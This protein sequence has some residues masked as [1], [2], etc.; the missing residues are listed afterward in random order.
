[1]RI[2]D[3]E[4]KPGVMNA[5]FSMAKTPEDVQALAQTDIGAIV[6]GSI[7]PEVQEENPEPRWFPGEGYA[8]NSFGMPN[9]GAEYYDEH[10]D[11]MT[12]IAHESDKAFILSVAGFSVAD[13]GQLAE[14]AGRHEVDMVEL[15]LGCPNI[16]VD[17]KQKPIASYDLDYLRSIVEAAYD[18]TKLPLSLKLSPYSNPAELERTAHTINKLPGVVSVVA[19][20]T[21]PNGMMFDNSGEPVLASKV[22]GLSGADMKRIALGQVWQFRKNLSDSI[23]VIGAGGIESRRD[24]QLFRNAGASAVQAATLMVR[25]GRHDAINDLFN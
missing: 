7:T 12:E 21:F 10:L 1:M 6:V 18:A 9:G 2:R 17:G 11:E 14:L 20:N 24:V 5:A 3:F 15:N 13:Y 8:L 19:S 22:G 23:A 4:I 16:S 25:A